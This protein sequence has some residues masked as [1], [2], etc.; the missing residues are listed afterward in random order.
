MDTSVSR[1]P[2]LKSDSHKTVEA[3]EIEQV[4]AVKVTDHVLISKYQSNRQM[5]C[6][7]DGQRGTCIAVRNCQMVATIL[8]QSRDQA[9][10]YLRQNHCGFEG[11][12]PLVCCLVGGNSNVNTRPGGVQTNPGTTGTNPEATTSSQNDDGNDPVYNLA[13]NPLLPNVCGRDL[14]QKIFGGERT[15]LDEFPWMALLEYQKPNGRTTACGGVLI[16]KRYILTAAHCIKGKDLP[17]TWRLTSVRLGEYNTETEQD[18][19]RDGEN[20][21]ICSDD[22]ISVGVEEQIAH[23]QYKPLSRDQ[24]NDIALLRL[25]R[26]VQFTRFIKPICL[27]SNSS[28]GNKFYVAGWGKTETRSASDVK[29][30]L[31]LPL[32]NKEQCEQTYSA[33]G[34]RLGLG[35]IC[36]GGQRGKDSCRGDSGGP[37]M[38]IE[39][40]ADGTG[41][42]TAIGVVSFGPSPCGMEGWPGVYSKVSDFVPW[43]LNNIRA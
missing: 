16:S 3:A 39:R 37:L 10:S 17:P 19:V 40:I 38:A 26:D 35:Q 18:C 33:A 22:P 1:C 30:K 14:S 9:I 20:S 41:R 36:A 32:T 27:P 21:M 28:L 11:S 42:W 4:F 23:E 8:Q 2:G 31:S 24:R 43:I 15:D 7:V 13:N 34:V 6:N 5:N 25:S 29:L 12:D